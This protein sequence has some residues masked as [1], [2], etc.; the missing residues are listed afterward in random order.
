MKVSPLGG[1]AGA[2]LARVGTRTTRRKERQP[3]GVMASVKAGELNLVE[4]TFSR[5]K[6]FFPFRGNNSLPLLL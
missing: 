1:V 6:K 3:V 4:A 2:T 5:L